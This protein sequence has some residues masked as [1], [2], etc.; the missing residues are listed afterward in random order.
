MEKKTYPLEN[1]R[2]R[3]KKGNKEEKR[4]ISKKKI[5]QKVK[6]KNQK[7]LGKR[8]FLNQLT[9]KPIYAL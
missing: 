7:K 9:L 8:I 4:S 6:V 1:S 5:K 2:S 3:G